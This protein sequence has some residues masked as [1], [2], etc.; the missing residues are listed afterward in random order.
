MTADSTRRFPARLLDVA[1]A[2]EYVVETNGLRSRTFRLDVADLPYTRRIDL[3]YRYPAYTALPVQRVDS[4][5]DIAAVLG[6]SVRVRVTPTKP[7]NGGRIVL[8]GGD[9]LHLTP[10]NDGSLVATL[11]VKRSGFY[12]VE[13]EGA[14]GDLLTASLDYAID[15]LPD[16]PP[17]VHFNKP[18]RDGKVLAVDEVY[19]E[20]RA[21]DD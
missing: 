11:P 7:T 10:T 19:T 12:R 3:E 13:L 16:R 2:T 5:G 20:A 15:A 1:R 14:R 18:G 8:E 9:T 4:A 17:T 6:T 21:A